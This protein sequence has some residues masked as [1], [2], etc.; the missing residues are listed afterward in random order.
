[1][2]KD[3]VYFAAYRFTADGQALP[4]AEE[5]VCAPAA[6]VMPGG[7]DWVGVGSGWAAHG[8]VL[9]E[10]AADRLVRVMHDLEPRAHDVAMLAAV[11]LRAG[12]V[13]D[14]A[15]AVPVYLRNNVADERKSPV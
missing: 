2:R 15:G 3:E 8:E 12:R 7:D 9:A 4:A 1:A 10:I 13:L 5:V 11:D 6:V 14:A